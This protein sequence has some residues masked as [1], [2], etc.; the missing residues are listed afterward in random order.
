M[1]FITFIIQFA[2]F[3]ATFYFLWMIFEKAGQ[4]GWYAIIPYYGAY[5]LAKIAHK[6]WT[7][8]VKLVASILMIVFIIG[9]CFNIVGIIMADNTLLVDDASPESANMDEILEIIFPMLTTILLIMIT[10][11]AIFITNIFLYIGLTKSFNLEWPFVLGLLFLN[12]VFMGIIALSPEI[13][14]ENYIPE[15]KENVETFENIE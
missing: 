13:Q 6:E 8:W 5:V 2:V 10:S 12:F 7:F 9:M 14:Y 15:T 3:I 1:E 4:K 11:L